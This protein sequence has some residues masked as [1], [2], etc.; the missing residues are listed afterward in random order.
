M[1]CVNRS[2]KGGGFLT[3]SLRDNEFGDFLLH[4]KRLCTVSQLK[5]KKAVSYCGLQL[6]DNH[7]IV[8]ESVWVLGPKVIIDKR[9]RLQVIY[10]LSTITITHYCAMVTECEAWYKD[11]L[12]VL[13][14]PNSKCSSYRLCY[15][16][17]YS[18]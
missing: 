10:I 15:I 1:R 14:F 4:K 16:Y 6:N 3:C 9:R 7:Q 8:P 5:L 11:T 18:Q 2:I 13:I 12:A 17:I